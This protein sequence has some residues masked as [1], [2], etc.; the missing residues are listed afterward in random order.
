MGM[1]E[2]AVSCACCLVLLFTLFTGVAGAEEQI[3]KLASWGPAKHFVAQARAEWIEAVNAASVGKI[4]IVEYPGGQLYGPK[5]MHK[6][7]AKGLVDIGVVLQPRMLAMVPML[8][9]VYLPFAFNTVDDTAKAYTGESL[10]IIEKAMAKKRIKMI[11]PSFVDGVQ[12]FSN[13]TNINTIE[14]FEGLRILAT[15]PIATEI[16]SR[17]GGAPDT[18]IPLTEQY[19]AMKRG[20]ADAI[21]SSIVNGYFQKYQE[22]T[23]FVTKM[24]LSFPT[25]LVC[26]NLK[27]WE[28][29]PKEVQEV[30]IAAGKKQTAHTIA[31]SKG[32]EQKFMA[33][34]TNAGATVT[35]IPTAER[36]KI[37]KVSSAVWEE[38]A[39]K[40]GKDAQRLLQ[41]SQQ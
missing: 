39:K 24:N 25:V 1:R 9:G 6:A 40:N 27:K 38:W 22:V 28:A 30:M 8:Q 37:K 26:M 19:M 33:E 17:L 13:K 16:L 34:L 18:S 11:Y 31:V 15:S 3:L 35:E 12:V 4:K 29:L 5:E 20:V 10:A 14:D 23:P 32:W 41:L 36:E 21:M 2:K 7:V